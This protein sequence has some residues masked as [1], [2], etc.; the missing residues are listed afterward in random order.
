MIYFDLL[1]TATFRVTYDLVIQCVA[2]LHAIDDLAFL[3]VAHTGT[4][5]MA[6]W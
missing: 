6:S 5:A 3:V 1:T 4:M 2:S